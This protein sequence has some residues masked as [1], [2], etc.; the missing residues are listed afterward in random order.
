[1]A[2]EVYKILQSRLRRNAQQR[3]TDCSDDCRKPNC[4][5]KS[6]ATPSESESQSGHKRR[7]QTS[8]AGEDPQSHKIIEKRRRDR[9]N[10]CLADL[11]HLIP[12]NYLKKGR[13]RIEKTEIV[14]M[15]IKHIKYLHSILPDSAIQQE[16]NGNET[17]TSQP[18]SADT[19]TDPSSVHFGRPTPLSW[20][21]PDDEES[22]KNGYNECKSEAL[23]F[24]VN[25][26]G[27][28]P[29]SP[30][31]TRLVDYLKG[32]L[33]HRGSHKHCKTEQMG[34]VDSDYSSLRS[35]HS[36]TNSEVGS[37]VSNTSGS[38]V[39]NTSLSSSFFSQPTSTKYCYLPS[40]SDRST[41]SSKSS[42]SSSHQH[43]NH[44]QGSHSTSVYPKSGASSS[45][46]YPKSSG[47]YYQVN[48]SSSSMDHHSQSEKHRKSS[49][50]MS[51]GKF[52][53]KDSIRERYVNAADETESSLL[54]SQKE[55]KFTE[56]KHSRS[57]TNDE[58]KDEKTTYPPVGIDWPKE[59]KKGSIPTFALHGSHYIPVPVA[60]EVIQPYI[61]LF[62][63]GSPDA[64][65]MLHPI[66]IPVN[67]CGPIQMAANA[68]S[69]KPPSSSSSSSKGSHS[70]SS[71]SSK[72]IKDDKD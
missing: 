61:H 2:D 6:S 62:E 53:F 23:H 66:T 52:K 57:D 30:I 9:M 33:D 36:A 17:T 49:E 69:T 54:A 7:R 13:G 60:E 21:Y 59:M 20:R 50:D 65:L 37:I 56:F 58:T 8:T 55:E 19:S 35:D 11:S 40:T 41:K 14:E 45:S 32:Y 38:V 26:G 22:F 25:S 43:H 64:P 12:S 3:T 51:S 39:S 34:I 10:S 18:S 63:R 42:S 44:H 5:Q 67:F 70:S 29:E 15:A 48:P 46:E 16:G 68:K 27:I 72:R 28:Q 4:H 24:L 71:S 1:M 31:C 47:G